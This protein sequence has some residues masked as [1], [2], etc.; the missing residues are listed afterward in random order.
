MTSLL[1]FTGSGGDAAQATAE[2]VAVHRDLSALDREAAAPI[3]SYASM[4]ET[5]TPAV[6]SI[7]VERRTS[8]ASPMRQGDPGED[9]LRRFFNLPPQRSQ[10]QPADPQRERFEPEGQGSG[11]IVSTDGYILTNNHVV[12]GRHGM[13]DNAKNV[14]VR[15][16]RVQLKD[17]REFPAEIVGTD[18]QTD[19]AVLKIEADDLPVV[20]LGNSDDLRVGDITF[21]VGNPLGVGLTV[22]QGIVS[23]LNRTDLGII[24][25]SLFES[26]MDMNLLPAIENF[27]QT[28]A[29]I[30]MGNSGGPLLDARGRV[31]GINSAISSIS[32]G[33]IGIGFAIPV[34]IAEQVMQA[35][36]SGEGIQRGFI[37][38]QLEPLDAD[39]ARAF[40]IDTTKGAIVNSVTPGLPGEQAGLQQGDIV[41][42][43]DGERVDTVRDMIYLISSR[44]PG[45]TVILEVFRWGEYLELPVTLGDRLALLGGEEAVAANG[46]AEAGSG[47]STKNNELFPGI[48]V[49]PLDE[50]I[51]NQI[52]MDDKRDG[53]V[54]LSVDTSEQFTTNLE[55]GMIVLTINGQPASDLERAREALKM[56]G[57]NALLVWTPQGESFFWLMIRE[58]PQE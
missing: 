3:Y 51:R 43:V 7:S 40:G 52:G 27:I 1:L 28:D 25:R 10:P 58:V 33:S 21:A 36:V 48:R 34:N 19:L 5:V 6:V 38:V 2:P 56:P 15:R 46:S 44:H 45:Q 41:V 4:L 32:G 9:M 23:A 8:A 12:E 39:K 20:V 29:A 37:G 57:S 11:F 26:G 54:V 47:P 50:S 22:S 14:E 30:N 16:I 17:G 55:S 35:I 49:R 42:A 18:P 13:L 24:D 53:L 31:I